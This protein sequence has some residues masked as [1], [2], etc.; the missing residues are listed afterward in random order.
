MKRKHSPVRTDDHHD[1]RAEAI[2]VVPPRIWAV[3]EAMAYV[4]ALVDPTGV[5]LTEHQRRSRR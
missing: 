4:G 3:L 2:P 5:L 1:D